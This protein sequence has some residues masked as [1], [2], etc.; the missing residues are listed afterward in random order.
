MR[1]H[2]FERGSSFKVNFTN[3]Y[4]FFSYATLSTNSTL[5]S[6]QSL[7]QWVEFQT[8]VA[9]KLWALLNAFFQVNFGFQDLINVAI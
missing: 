5:Y 3:F 9:S 4:E 8:S 2:Y 1:P 7:N 6:G